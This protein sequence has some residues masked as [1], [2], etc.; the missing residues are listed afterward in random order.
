MDEIKKPQLRSIKVSLIIT[1]LIVLGVSL[2]VYFRVFPEL[3]AIVAENSP[4]QAE[5][6]KSRLLYAMTSLL[7]F[8]FL[9]NFYFWRIANN[10]EEEEKTARKT[11]EINPEDPTI[12]KKLK[13]I[14]RKRKLYLALIEPIFI[15]VLGLIIACIVYIVF[16]PLYRLSI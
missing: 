7:I 4:T 8:L 3:L 1:S 9:I 16:T 2:F 10:L 6:M 14:E 15:I 13:R 11:L 5:T 12:Q